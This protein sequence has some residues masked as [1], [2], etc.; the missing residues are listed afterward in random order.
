MSAVTAVPVTGTET[1]TVAC[2]V[3]QGMRL[4]LHEKRKVTE[5]TTAGTKTVEQWFETDKE[6]IINGPA[7]PQNEGPRCQVIAGFAITRGV[8]KDLWDAWRVQNRDLPAMKN[9]LIFAY[10]SA[11]KAIDAARD[12]KAIKSGLERINP[13]DPP[14]FDD[15]FRLK[16]ADENLSQIGNVEE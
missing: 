1:V 15:R 10:E 6:F 5:V 3:P 4:R 8:P 7:H 9:G 11:D 14:R 12:G 2:K 13:H 16:T